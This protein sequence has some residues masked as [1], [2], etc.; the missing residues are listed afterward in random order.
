M[1]PSKWNPKMI[2]IIII[3]FLMHLN[4]HKL[5]CRFKG[6]YYIL[7][8]VRPKLVEIKKFNPVSAI[9]KWY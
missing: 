8:N 6:I 5:Y 3:I 7:H 9:L 1:L 2:I 4:Q